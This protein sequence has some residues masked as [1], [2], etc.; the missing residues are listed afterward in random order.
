LDIYENCVRFSV[1]VKMGTNNAGK[2]FHLSRLLN[3]YYPNTLENNPILF[4][5]KKNWV[6][7]NKVDYNNLFDI[8][9][10]GT[11]KH[12]TQSY[13]LGGITYSIPE[14]TISIGEFGVIINNQS[15]YSN[16]IRNKYKVNLRSIGQTDAYYWIVGDDGT[17]LR[18]RK[19]DFNIENIEV[20]CKCPR[21]NVTT[22][23]RSVSFFNNLNGVVVGDLN[24]ILITNDGGIKWERH[25]I[26]A[27]DAFY[28][29]KVYFNDINNFYIGGNNGVFIHFKK[30]INNWTAYKRRISKFIDDEDE[31]LLVDNIND[32]L[33]TDVDTWSPY[34]QFFTQSTSTNKE[35]LFLVTDN[36]NIILHDI[37]NSIPF[38]TD[39]MY[40]EMDDIDY[41]D[42]KTIE[43]RFGEDKFYF[44]GYDKINEESGIFSFQ[45]SNFDSI[46]FGNSFSNRIY[47]TFSAYFESDSYPND[48]FDYKGDELILSGNNSM[49][50]SSTYSATFSFSNIDD[51]LE[52]RLRSKLLFWIMM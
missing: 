11:L 21:K 26:S 29:N 33:K 19:H 14:R 3:G 50:L 18:V 25:L 41:G 34:Y 7:R 52:S 4:K 17:L 43:K 38:H 46:G 20:D 6:I 10:Y 44:T 35:L 12:G 30:D 45:L 2:Q 36:N 42:I 48:I 9:Y 40:L 13:E 39:F 31:F 1:C 37:D 5:E 8:N 47:S 15:S 49:L 24:T 16:I 51:E 27:F 23:L 28:Y 22:N 32:I